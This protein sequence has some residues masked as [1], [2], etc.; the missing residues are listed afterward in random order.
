MDNLTINSDARKEIRTLTGLRGFAA[1]WVLV[2]HTCFGEVNE[3]GYF[4]AFDNRVDWGFLTNFILFGYLAVDLFFILSGFVMGY[5][6]QDIFRH[7]LA[8]RETAGFYIKRLA[9]IYPVHALITLVLAAFY[10]S[11]LWTPFQDFTAERVW[12]SLGLL[13]VL[14]HPS[15]NM[16][17]WSVSAEWLAYLLCP[18][19]LWA[20]ARIRQA[21]MIVLPVMF[22]LFI[23][24]F[25]YTHVFCCNWLAGPAAVVRVIAGFSIGCLLHRFYETGHGAAFLDKHSGALFLASFAVLFALC[26]V[27]VDIAYVYPVLPL[28]I[29]F[30]VRARGIVGA[31]FSSR[32]MVF[33]GVIS[34]CIYMVHYPVLEIFTHFLSDS[35]YALPLDYPQ[36]KLWALAAFIFMSVIGAATLLYFGVERPCRRWIIRRFENRKDGGAAA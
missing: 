20:T 5:V 14:D 4:T 9:R 21:W 29:F 34:Y 17:A 15:S 26:T 30:L 35:I 32:L 7:R 24:P 13:N 12:L 10:F 31:A 16:P 25:L 2:L 3:F 36:A 11:T 33:L 19:I 27:I 23:Y 28:I 22:L 1:I 6:Y 18:F 8:L